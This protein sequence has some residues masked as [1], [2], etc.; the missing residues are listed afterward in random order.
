MLKTQTIK[1]N[2]ELVPSVLVKH[3]HT[4]LLRR[5]ESWLSV[6]KDPSAPYKRT[7]DIY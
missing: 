2:Q 1:T 6:G 5:I 3:H 7:D 4:L